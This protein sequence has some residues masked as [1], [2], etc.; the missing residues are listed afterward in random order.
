MVGLLYES[1]CT[2][3]ILS[4]ER[5]WLLQVFDGCFSS[6]SLLKASF[7]LFTT[8]SHF[9]QQWRAARI[10]FKVKKLLRQCSEVLQTLSGLWTKLQPLQSSLTLISASIV[11]RLRQHCWA[12]PAAAAF[13][14]FECTRWRWTDLYLYPPPMMIW[15]TTMETKTFRQDKT[16]QKTDEMSGTLEQRKVLIKKKK[17]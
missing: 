7:F 16:W 13:Q 12:S 4:F 10:W 3:F 2:I 8:K 14:S 5:C 1:S 11:S 6:L 17:T 15:C 9:S